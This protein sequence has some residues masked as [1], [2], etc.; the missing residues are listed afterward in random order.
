[1][2]KAAEVPGKRDPETG[3]SFKKHGGEIS[4]IK[5]DL[6]IIKWMMGFVLVFQIT[7][8]FEAVLHWAV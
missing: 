4:G 6:A 8:F 3:L 1:M 2:L 7:I 5:T